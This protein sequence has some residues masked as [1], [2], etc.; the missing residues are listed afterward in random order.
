MPKKI[1]TVEDIR[2]L[3]A[4]LGNQIPE[5]DKIVM[6]RVKLPIPEDYGGG[7][8]T[9]K[10]MDE[11]VLRLLLK[12][13]DAVMK[14]HQ[15]IPFEECAERW[16][17]L[18]KGQERS[19]STLA[20]YRR[21]LDKHILPFF[22]GKRVDQIKAEHI[23]RYFNSIM[24]MSK[25]M[26]TQSKA[27]LC[28]IFDFAARNEMIDKNPMQFRYE[29]SKKVGKKVVLQDE[30]LISVID[31]L[32]K[33]EGKDY[34][35]ACFLCFTSLRRGEIL[36]LKWG[37]LDFENRVIHV[38]RSVSFPDGQN[39][40]V[41][42]LPKDNSTGDVLLQS[43]LARRL[44]NRTGQAAT[45]VIPYSEEAPRKPITKSMFTKMWRRINKA[46][47]LK[48]ATSHSFR[49]TYATMM[50]AHCDHID[51]KALQGALR[52]KTP[53]LAIKVYTKENDSKTRQAEMEYDEWI[54]SQLKQASV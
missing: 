21:M 47:D 2:V 53:D 8:V 54:C 17:R 19:A 35:Y 10:T 51:P 15:A 49:A 13:K 50:N 25:S 39:D 29:K 16:F 42:D 5:P 30:D 31:Q 24:S 37:D 52:H 44:S 41:I 1:Y 9:G 34:L 4:N 28:G 36:G 38:R 43:E 32:N 7:Y 6:K 33:L 20:N 26:S 11:A 27:V 14:A 18:K 22:K 12:V 45:Y 23:Q 3:L 48:G 46:I 40:S